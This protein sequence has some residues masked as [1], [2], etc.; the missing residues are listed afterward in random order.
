MPSKYEL[1][2]KNGIISFYRNQ[3]IKF[4]KIGMGNKTEH[5]VVVTQTLIDMT[6]LRLNQLILKKVAL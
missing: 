4:Q 6:V 3:L 5:G 2:S 1:S